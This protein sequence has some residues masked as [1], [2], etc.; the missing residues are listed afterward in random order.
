MDRIFMGMPDILVSDLRNK[1]YT[2]LDA[3]RDSLYDGLV[4]KKYFLQNP[5]SVR[6]IYFVAGFIAGLLVIFIGS[7]SRILPT[8]FLAG[9]LTCLCV[10]A[11]VKAMPAKTRAGALAHNEILGFQ[12]FFK[13]RRKGQAG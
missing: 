3:L 1:F 2:N 11:F 10:L 9:I 8:G 5:Q 4:S 7:F 6:S 12:E 13:P